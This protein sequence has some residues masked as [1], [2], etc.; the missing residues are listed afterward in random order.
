MREKAT[1]LAGETHKEPNETN[2]EDEQ[3]EEAHM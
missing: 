3:R 1:G 2:N